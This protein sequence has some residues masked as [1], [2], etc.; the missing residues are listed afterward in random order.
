VTAGRITREE[1]ERAEREAAASLAARAEL[2][3]S[4]YIKAKVPGTRGHAVFYPRGHDAS[5]SSAITSWASRTAGRLIAEGATIVSVG[6]VAE[7]QS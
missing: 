5:S 6:M 2:R 4:G 1:R 7:V 3:W